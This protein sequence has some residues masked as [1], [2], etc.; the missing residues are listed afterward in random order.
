[1]SEKENKMV[2]FPRPMGTTAMALEYQKN[3]NDELL[4][5][6]HNYII[7]Q[8]LM[9]NGVL[10]GIT[11]DINTF[12]YRMGIDINY[13]RVFM[14]DRLLSSRIW[15]KEKAEDLLQALMGEQLAWAL[16]DRME[17][18]HQVNILRESQGGEYVPF[19]SAELGKALKLKLESSTSLQSIVRN[20]TGGSTT[21]IFAQFNQQNN[22]TQQNAITVEEARQIVLESQRVLDKPEEAKLLEDRYDIKSLPEVVATKQEGVDTSKEGLNLNK[23]ELM[24]ITDDYK[25]AMSSFSKEHHELRREIEMRI[26]PDEEDPELYQYE[27]FEEEEKED[28]SFASQFLRNSKLP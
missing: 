9:G 16:E 28:G 27:D 23:A 26:D 19:I 17:I 15:D 14:R 22:V 18:A 24:Q 1:M 6:I 12:S 3:P 21:N 10:C 20:L 13:I 4:I 5:K 7:N 2:R 11:Y 25:G 8:W